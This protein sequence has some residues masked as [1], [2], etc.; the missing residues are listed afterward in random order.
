MEDP[1]NRQI[2]PVQKLRARNWN[3]WLTSP[4]QKCEKFKN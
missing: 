4:F 2:N 1:I 3:E